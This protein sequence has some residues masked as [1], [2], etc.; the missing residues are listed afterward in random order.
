[1]QND[2]VGSADHLNSP[3]G[4]P[5]LCI[6][7]YELCIPKG[8]F[9]EQK[10]IEALLSAREK[11][12]ALGVRIRPIQDLKAARRCLSGHKESDGF[13]AL[14]DL[15]R[16]DLTLEAL[17]VQKGFTQLFTDQQANTAL[18]RLLSAGWRFT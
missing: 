10:F 6:M 2:C 9:M 16:L 18:E 12:G 7:H 8:Y 15:G 3:E 17:A 11:A 1:M 5:Q 4:T 14:A 13:W